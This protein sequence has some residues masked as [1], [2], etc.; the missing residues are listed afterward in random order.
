ML[1]ALR[2]ELSSDREHLI[3]AIAAGMLASEI[4]I[5]LAQLTQ[6]IKIGAWT[7]SVLLLII[8][9]V[10]G[11][12]VRERLVRA[13]HTTQTFSKS[14]WLIPLLTALVAFVEF[15]VSM[16]P[17]TGSDALQY[18]FTVQKEILERGFHPIFSNSHSFLC[19]QHHLLILFGLSLGSERLAMGFIFLGGILTASAFMSLTSEWSS[20]KT[21]ATFTLLF[22]LTPVVFWQMSSS[23]AP[24]IFIAFLT[25]AGVI[26][27][28]QEHYANRWQQMVLAGFLVGG[29]AGA[30]YT[31][32][33]IAV[34]FA[35]AIVIEFRSTKQLTVFISASL[36]SGIWPYLR[37]VAWTRNPVFPFLSK[38]LSPDLVTSIA[39]D[40]L[41]ADTGT[42]SAHHLSQLFPF[43][44]LAAAQKG[45]P[46]MWDYFGP[47]VLALA[48]LLL[49]AIKKIRAWR[50]SMLVWLLYSTGVFFASGL[51]RLLLPVF[52]VALSCVA[53]GAEFALHQG[54]MV[55]RRTAIGIVVV[56]TVSG[57]VGLVVYGWRPVLSAVGIVSKIEYLRQTSQD[58]EV[59]EA[60]NNLLGGAEGPRRVLVFIRHTYYLQVPIVNGDPGTSFELDVTKL[61]RPQDWQRFFDKANVGYVVRSPNYPNSIASTLTDME[62]RG[63]LICIAQTEVQNLQGMRVDQARSTI[64]VLILEVKRRAIQGASTQIDFVECG[65]SSCWR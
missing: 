7:I 64:P 11:K 49:L 12:P 29:I 50:I 19:G 2:M 63:D 39:M 46:G 23:G 58:Y 16:A 14:G 24:D 21:A 53:A 51:P 31:G 47:T 9:A 30:K 55:V 18:H 13:V 45:K 34:A 61:Q 36:L 52:P 5:F 3:V 10:H 26:V 59:A 42:K 35:I 62:K 56:M 40:N 43:A 37:N 22:L 48:P 27:L 54:L 41:A 57:A 32:A 65:K 4:A 1:R 6:H 17:V 25:C 20:E 28:R 8:L 33:L 60:V 38:I 15:L 44:F